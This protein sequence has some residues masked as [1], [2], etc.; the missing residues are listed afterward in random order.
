M[1]TQSR[2]SGLRAS[3]WQDN[4]AAIVLRSPSSPPNDDWAADDLPI[5]GTIAMESPEASPRPPPITIGSPSALPRVPP[6]AIARPK[7]DPQV[8]SI[9]MAGISAFLETA[10]IAMAPPTGTGR[11]PAIGM[12]SAG[13]RCE[14]VPSLTGRAIGSATTQ[15]LGSAGRARRAGAACWAPSAWSGAPLGRSRS[16][17]SR[18]ALPHSFLKST[19]SARTTHFRAPG[20]AG[21]PPGGGAAPGRASPSAPGNGGGTGPGCV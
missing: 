10:A 8:R 7:A 2:L 5:G 9:T 17:P 12:R 13:C 20:P 6:I 4:H 21:S 1:L 18:P 14:R 3:Q 16:G 11:A 15:P 19:A